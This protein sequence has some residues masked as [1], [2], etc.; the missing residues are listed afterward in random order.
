[1]QR[2]YARNAKDEKRLIDAGVPA[3]SIY[4]Q[5]RG[6]EQFGQWKM[7]KGETLA[8]VN[9]LYAFGVT[10]KAMM[11]ALDQVQKWGAV[12]VDVETGHRS[13]N[14]SAKLLDL[15]LRRR[16]GELAM[17]DGQAEE[18][19][20]A[21]VLARLKGR[22]PIRNAKVFW[23]NPELTTKQALHRMRG[24][25]QGTAYRAFGKRSVPSGRPKLER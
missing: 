4:R 14:G 1:M 15:G 18:M 7:R 16:H 11:A 12:I 6:A 10:R 3:R 23:M 13:D 19:Q 21:S 5:D 2:G 24:W 8:V 17:K 20:E 22:M 9:G 25:S